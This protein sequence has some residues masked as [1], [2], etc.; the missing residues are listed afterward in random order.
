MQRETLY[1]E[2]RRIALVE[3]DEDGIVYDEPIP[4]RNLEYDI[5]LAKE[6]ERHYDVLA[7]TVGADYVWWLEKRLGHNILCARRSL[8][9][10]ALTS[11]EVVQEQ[12]T[13]VHEL[14]R[15]VQEEIPWV[16]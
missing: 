11:N 8:N 1:K 16:D 12:F 13:S 7:A 9:E 2:F 10:T 3:E 6:F 14:V 5:K 4:S 15:K